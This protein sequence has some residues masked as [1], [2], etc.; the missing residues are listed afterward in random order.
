MESAAAAETLGREIEAEGRARHIRVVIADDSAVM[1]RVITRILEAEADI[2]VVGAA[3]D[4]AEAVELV[5]SL[6][7]DA[8]T[9]DVN[10]PRVDGLR[11]IE[12]IMGRNPTPIVLLSA[13]ARPGGR[14][15]ER[16]LA[17]GVVHVVTK[18]SEFGIALDLDLQAEELRA[19]V[20]SAARVR[21]IRNA[22]FGMDPA[23]QALD[24]RG[25]PPRPQ[26]K[27]TPLQSIPVIAI[28]ASTGGTV[29]LGDMLPL[30]PKDL[31]ACVLIVQHMP[32]GYTAEWAQAL[33]ESTTLTVTEA[34]HGDFLLPGKVF[35]APG[36]HHMEVKGTHIRL[37]GGPRVKMHRPSVDVLFDSL[38]PVAGLVCAVLLTG[39]GDDGVAGMVRLHAAGAHSLVQDRGSAVVWGMPGAAVRAGCVRKQLPPAEMTAELVREVAQMIERRQGNRPV[40][41]GTRS[42][43]P[44]VHS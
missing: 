17:L 38:L 41:G 23:R 1:R 28:G 11:A 3:R 35:V 4:G 30:F 5:T 18:P 37:S 16:A 33:N 8:I 6:H 36:G 15:V 13:F 22:S 43:R 20:R 12:T 39:M 26:P 31:G 24:A 2:E 44:D 7:P 42:K 21:V 27:A 34:R 9:M 19:K 29:V 10:M 32:P 14:V 40:P 25:C